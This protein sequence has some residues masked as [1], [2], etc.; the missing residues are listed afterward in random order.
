MPEKLIALKGSIPV[1]NHQLIGPADPKERIEV[2]LKLR[3]KT[4]EGLPTLDEFVAGKRAVGITRQV[5]SEKYGANQSDADEVQHWAVQ[6]GLLVGHVDL[7]KRQMHLVGS[8]DAMSHAFGVKLQMHRHGRTH[9]NFRFPDR[10]IQV[11]EKLAPI[12]AG[13][14][15]LSNMPVV[16]RHRAVLATHKATSTD[17]KK[18]FPGSF[19]PNEVAKLYNFP[20]TQ[21]AGQRVAILE[22]GGGFDQKVLADYFTQNIGL[23]TPPT[24]NALFVLDAQMNIKDGATG[25]VYL[26]IEVV[27]AMAPK[28]N[29]DVYFAPWSGQGYLNAIDQAIHNDDYA[30]ISISYGL[31]E[32][33]R[34]SAG[35]PG[36][37]MLNQNIDEGFRDATAIGIP[38]F[39]STGDQGS[40]SLRGFLPDQYQTEVTAFSNTAHAG[41]PG[42]SPYATA[43]G[44]TMLYAEN[45]AISK[46]IV[47]NELGDVQEGSY[48]NQSGKLQNGKF[49]YGGATGGGV[50]DRYK[51]VP[52]Y[53]TGA[54]ISP[55]SVNGSGAKGRGVPD[56]AGNSGSTTG[57]LVSQPPGSDFPIAPVGGTSAAA[58]MWAAL[59]ACIRESLNA[60]FAGKVPVFFFND[61][62]YANGKSAAFNDIVEGRQFSLVPNEGL[63]P[64]DF[65]PIGSNCSTQAKG[66]NAAPGYDL[67]TGWGSPNGNELLKLLQTWLAKQPG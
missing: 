66:Y 51:T 6:Q 34:G 33:L 52:S 32:D 19:Y 35:D 5:L 3:R 36:W 40:S 57:Y 60:S 53:Q 8:V 25:E 45:G 28:A 42:T 1:N 38:I 15:G 43:V 26:D 20:S 12:I 30:A 4:E 64:G 56:V 58:P 55:Q 27:G 22:F 46:E 49:Y 67:C 50:S 23:A 18:Q 2:T 11:P 37:P 61:F 59:M 14:F 17:P 47:W 29:I 65:I 48:Y 16:V 7:G 10:E 44:G 31:D 24:V 9:T 41:Y 62:V 63:E 21:G 54:G 39:V 13:V